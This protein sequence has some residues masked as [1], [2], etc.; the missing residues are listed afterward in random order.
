[1]GGEVECRI[2]SRRFESPHWDCPFLPGRLSNE[3]KIDDRSSPSKTWRAM[4]RND[5]YGVSRSSCPLLK[6]CATRST[7][8]YWHSTVDDPL[9]YLPTSTSATSRMQ[10]GV[11]LRR[12][13][14]GWRRSGPTRR[15][16]PCRSEQRCSRPRRDRAR[17]RRGAPRAPR[18]TPRSSPRGRSSR[19]CGRSSRRC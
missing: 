8:R 1:V 4:D 7:V 13:Y 2:A 12:F 10:W 19:A 6:P 15:A 18:R 9:H 3:P 14:V 17:R 16:P 5:C 11:S